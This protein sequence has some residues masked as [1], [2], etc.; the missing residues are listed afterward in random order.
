MGKTADLKK[1][2]KEQLDTLQGVTYYRRAP[3]TA[4]FPYK[5]FSLQKVDTRTDARDDIDLCVDIWDKGL[6][7]A[8][9]ELIGDQV[10]SLLDNVNLPQDTIL[11]TIYRESRYTVDDADPT[12]Q[13]VQLHFYINFYENE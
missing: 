8:R 5:V 3:E 6:S 4:A 7:P 12:I 10:E 1:L 2:I 13:R 9:V 11:P